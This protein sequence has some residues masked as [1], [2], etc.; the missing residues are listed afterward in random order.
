MLTR[1][2]SCQVASSGTEAA[3]AGYD[4]WFCRQPHCVLLW[5]SKERGRFRLS[6]SFAYDGKAPE[7]VQ[8]LS[9]GWMLNQ[10]F[11]TGATERFPQELNQEQRVRQ[12]PDIRQ[13]CVKGS[14]R[15]RI[16]QK[17]KGA[18]GCSSGSL[19]NIGKK[20]TGEEEE[21]RRRRKGMTRKMGQDV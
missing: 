8:S 2:G 9:F 3:E 18:G 17:R 15:G 7:P 19:L 12:W 20:K 6:D 13:W 4:S 14:G 16:G 10:S 11:A 5:S 1:G 21:E